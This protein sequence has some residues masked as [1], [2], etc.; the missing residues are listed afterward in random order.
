MSSQ[1]G[2][3][4]PIV[5]F[6]YRLLPVAIGCVVLF[7]LLIVGG[8]SVQGYELRQE[9]RAVETRIDNF[10]KENRRLSTELQYYRSDEYI[11]KVAREELGL[12]RPGDVAVAIVSPE[13]R[14]S[15]ARAAKPTP[16]PTPGSS[17]TK[18]A[19]WQR[20]MSLFVDKK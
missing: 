12:I 10:K 2:R 13:D 16:V 3:S 1:S 4:A 15:P 14:Q 6:V 7:V 18:S 8:K 5:V 9:A 11:E 20:W 17:P 19:N